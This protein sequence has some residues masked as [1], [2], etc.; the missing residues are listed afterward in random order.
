MSHKIVSRHAVLAALSRHIGAKAGINAKDL[1][2]EIAGVLATSGTERQLRSMIEMLRKEGH[3]VCGTP[4][5]G[6]FMAAS[7]DELRQ[8][9]EFLYA[10]AMTSLGQIAAMQRVSVPDLRGQLRL[11][12]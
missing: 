6:Y 2:R 5:H 7:V 8:T 12:S 11:P 10:R 3:H 1:S 9:C 4:R